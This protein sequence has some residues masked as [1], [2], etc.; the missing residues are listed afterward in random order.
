MGIYSA[1]RSGM[2]ESGA[3]VANENYTSSDAG[4]I[5]YESQVNDM[6]IFEAIIA[7]DLQEAK[8]IQEGT[9]LE[10]EAVKFNRQ[11]ATGILG[12]LEERLKYFWGKVKGLLKDAMN[13][14]AAYVL[15]DGKAFAKEFRKKFEGKKVK[16]PIKAVIFN[17]PIYN[18]LKDDALKVI[19]MDSVSKTV[20][21]Y[22]YNE[23][24]LKSNEIAKK[25][26]G[27]DISD[28]KENF[29]NNIVTDGTISPSSIDGLVDIVENG[30]KT[31]AEMKAFSNHVDKSFKS[32][33]AYIKSLSKAKGNDDENYKVKNATAACSAFEKLSSMFSQL[34]VSGAKTMVKQCRINLSNVLS[35]AVQESAVLAEAAALDA[36]A[37]VDDAMSPEVSTEIEDDPELKDAVEDVVDSPEVD[38]LA[39]CLR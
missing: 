38:D 20:D 6:A 28:Y 19:N 30:K 34:I 8:A 10:S 14:I 33:I 39:E 13:K 35:E 26:L 25:L 5:I 2:M 21:K 22:A 37:E 24:M 3:I 29:K 11:N 32:A 9:L 7:S 1:N 31:I 4:R 15:R 36:E 18:Q 23:D 27:E 16:E 12:K 17:Y